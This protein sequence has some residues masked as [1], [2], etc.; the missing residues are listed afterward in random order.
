MKNKDKNF[1]YKLRT[2]KI[3]NILKKRGLKHGWISEQIGISSQALSNNFKAR[4]VY[5][6]EELA[7]ILD[8]EKKSLFLKIKRN[9][10]V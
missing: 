7:E 4:S 9:E 6:V 3:K 2:R 5:Y 1:Y 8:V 10:K